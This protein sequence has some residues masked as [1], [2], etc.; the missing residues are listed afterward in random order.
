MIGVAIPAHNEAASLAACLDSVLLATRHPALD[1]ERTEVIV[2]LDACTDASSRIAAERGV[3]TIAIDA[4]NVGIARALG[5]RC[6][7]GAGSRWLAFTDADSRVAPDW[8]A[9]QLSLRADA[10]CGCIE[11]DDW[12]G[13]TSDIRLRFL[14]GYTHADG[15][16]HIHGANLG[17]SS[18]AYRRCG[19]FQPVAVSEDV[20]LVDALLRCEAKIV[21][22]AA[23][24][25]VT[26][27]RANVRARGGFGDTLSALGELAPH[28]TPALPPPAQM[29][30]SSAPPSARSAAL[31]SADA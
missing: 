12:T 17:V 5:A 24:R 27:A 21:W 28:G 4:R 6:L 23:P 10:V 14:E 20:A 22:S 2:V 13:R 26:S 25:V 8:L 9:A 16:R 7:L 3:R 11:V 31:L 19:G 30:L 18:H 15:H 29:M 1:G